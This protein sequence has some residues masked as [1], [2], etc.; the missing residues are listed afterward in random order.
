MAD[1]MLVTGGSRGIGA[2]TALL[3]ARRGWA[4]GISYRAAAAEADAVVRAVRDAGGAAVAVRADVADEA[5]VLR[6]FD[7]VTGHLGPVHSLVNNAGTVGSYGPAS[8]LRVDEL[9]RLLDVNVVG[10]FVCAREAIR[11]MRTDTGGTG[12]TIVNVSSRASVLGGATEWVTYAASKGAIDAMTVGLSKELAPLGIRV[13]AVRPG[14]IDTDIHGA[15]PPGRVDRLLPNVPMARAG[16]PVE[17]AEA[18]VWLASE[19]SSYVTGGFVD[20][21]GGR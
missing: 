7:T 10:A 3:A 21:G 16:T 20:V 11:Q 19:A 2:A 6:L 1:V 4:V 5:D 17:V 13:N 12:G 9:R 18:I 8:D 14:L 15:A